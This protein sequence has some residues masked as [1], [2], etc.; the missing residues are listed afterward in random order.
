MNKIL[1]PCK[2]L[3]ELFEEKKLVSL[4]LSFFEPFAYTLAP[5]FVTVYT[6]LLRVFLVTIHSIKRLVS[7]N[8]KIQMID[9]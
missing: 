8:V 5:V 4:F 9:C 2:L 6:N 1:E 7:K 3:N